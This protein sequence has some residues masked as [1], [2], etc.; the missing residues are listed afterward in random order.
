VAY[1]RLVVAA[2]YADAGPLEV[3]RS[4]AEP[5]ERALATVPGLVEQ[6]SVVREGS[7][8]TTVR[9]AWDT[10]MDFAALGVRER[11]DELRDV[12]PRSATRPVVLRADPSAE[13]FMAVSVSSPR[14]AMRGSAPASGRTWWR[15]AP[16]RSRS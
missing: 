12:L 1:P 2:S 7:S 10:D 8:L 15:S 4:L 9:F 6:Q 14:R 13:P 5:I 3:E 11:L 16:S